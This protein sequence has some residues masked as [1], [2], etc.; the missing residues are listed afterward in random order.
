MDKSTRFCRL[1]FRPE[2]RGMLKAQAAATTLRDINKDVDCF[3]YTVNVT[4]CPCAH[5][6]MK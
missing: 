3:A 2:Q 1:F 6:G 4:V 5:F